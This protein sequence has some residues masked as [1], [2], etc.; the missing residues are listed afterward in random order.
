MVFY[1][2]G[3]KSG[4]VFRSVAVNHFLPQSTASFDNLS[5]SNNTTVSKEP[6]GNRFSVLAFLE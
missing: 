2:R 4:A 6:D 3:R 5:L 1:S